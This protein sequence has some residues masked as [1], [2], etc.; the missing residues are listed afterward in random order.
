MTSMTWSWLS[1]ALAFASALIWFVAAALV[2][3]PNTAWFVPG[4]GG[5]RPSPEFDAILKKLRWQS[6][7]NAA[8]AFAMA[9]SALALSAALL[10][11]AN[12]EPLPQPKVGQCPAGYRESG[13]YCASMSDKAP[14]AIP[15]V[16][17][18]PSGWMQSGLLC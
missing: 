17:Q 5:G 8:A 10:T 15:K 12:A 6:R 13:G 16:G 18:C 1:T 7:L 9:L 11:T 3:L 14:I 2:P 4:A